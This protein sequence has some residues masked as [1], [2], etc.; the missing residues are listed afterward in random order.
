MAMRASIEEWERAFRV[1]GF[2]P[3][4]VGSGFGCFGAGVEL[5]GLS[6]W[7]WMWMARKLVRSLVNILWSWMVGRGEVGLGR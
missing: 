2:G 3:F 4:G 5:N 7:R 1:V 6:G